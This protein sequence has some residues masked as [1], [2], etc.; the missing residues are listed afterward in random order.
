MAGLGMHGAAA[1]LLGLLVGMAM[2]TSSGAGAAEPS[3]APRAI[4]EE[5]LAQQLPLL[6]HRN[7]IV[8][9]DAAYPAQ[10]R[11]GITTIYAGGDHLQVIT[12]VLKAIDAARHVSA[13]PL[14]DAELQS[15]AEDDA[16]GVASFRQRLEQLL[17]GRPAKTMPHEEVIAE[18]D[19]AAKVFQVLVIKTDMTVPYTSVFLRLE[20]GYWNAEKEQRLRSALERGR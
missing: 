19:E 14:V 4:W 5:V 13:T 12:T 8:I 7:W 9:A 16:P 1:V 3:K 2:L 18:L 17:A 6:G 11:P 20:C 10:S 15:V